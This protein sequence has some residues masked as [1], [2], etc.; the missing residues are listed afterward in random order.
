MMHGGTWEGVVPQMLSKYRKASSTMHRAMYERYMRVILCADCKGARL[1][2]QA[3]F[4]RVAGKT[5]IE[6]EAMP[7]EDLVAFLDNDV[8][9]SLTQVE[10]Q[11]ASELLKEIRTR[12]GFLLDVGLG[13][14]ALERSATTLSGG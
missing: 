9:R 5:L 11:V 13:Y 14:L 2:E 7:V 8:V 6:V 3:R 4:V 1:N 12:L 10:A